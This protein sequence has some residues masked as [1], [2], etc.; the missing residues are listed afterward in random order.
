MAQGSVVTPER[1]KSGKTYEEYINSGIRNRDLFDQ[2]YEGTR[3]SDEQAQALK[4]LAAKPNGPDHVMVV[5]EDWCPDVYRGMP[6]AARIAEAAGIEMRVFERDQNKDIIAEYLKDGEFESIPVFVF[7]DRDHN[8]ITHFI[9]RPK[10]ANE[11]MG[12]VR[13]VTKPYQPD[14]IAARLGRQPTDEEM[15]EARAEGRQK[16]VEFQ[17]G[18]IWANWRN[19]T[20]DEVI[21]L[22]RANT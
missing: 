19:A 5:G 17:Q 18:D 13:E 15:Q 7:Y 4:D 21:G 1:F 14:A 6:V 22:L 10:L 20:V 9:E 16:F 12:H 11:E 3:I 2:N 8:E